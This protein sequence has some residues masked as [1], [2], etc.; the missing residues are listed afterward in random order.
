MGPQHTTTSPLLA[1]EVSLEPPAAGIGFLV[2]RFF[3]LACPHH[4]SPRPTQ[5]SETR[6][7]GHLNH[8]CIGKAICGEISCTSALLSLTTR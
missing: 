2:A 4:L 5:S 6:G 1:F 8:R 7:Q 3:V